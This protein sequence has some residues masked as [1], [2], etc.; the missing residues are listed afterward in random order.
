MANAGKLVSSVPLGAR[1]VGFVGLENSESNHA[2][3]V[4]WRPQLRERLQHALPWLPTPLLNGV[5]ASFSWEPDFVK[6]RWPGVPLTWMDE[7]S[8]DVGCVENKAEAIKTLLS[9]A[10]VGEGHDL[11][12]ATRRVQRQLRAESEDV[13]V[14]GLSPLETRAPGYFDRD[15]GMFEKLKLSV[16]SAGKKA[17][18][19]VIVGPKHMV[20]DVRTLMGRCLSAGYSSSRIWFHEACS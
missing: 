19:I 16:E 9:R 3:M 18:A 4:S 6:R 10:G 8:I 7:R 12:E 11:K 17:S 13:E 5:V 14:N 20:D 15:E 1:G 2:L